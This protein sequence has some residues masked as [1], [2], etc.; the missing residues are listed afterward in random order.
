MI[1]DEEWAQPREFLAGGVLCSRSYWPGD[2]PTTAANKRPETGDQQQG[3]VYDWWRQLLHQ[4]EP[5][6]LTYLQSKPL[7]RPVPPPPQ[8]PLFNVVQHLIHAGHNV[9]HIFTIL[10]R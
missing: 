8:Q 6:C 2:I 10:R 7:E 3:P 5:E 1:E 9:Q 4:A